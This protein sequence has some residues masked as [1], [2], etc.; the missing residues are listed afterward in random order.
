VWCSA[1]VCTA[2]LRSKSTE[3]VITQIV[4]DKQNN[5]WSYCSA[6]RLE[7]LQLVLM[8][9]LTGSHR[10]DGIG[11]H[12]AAAV[13]IDFVG[14]AERGFRDTTEGQAEQFKHKKHIK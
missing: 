9:A 3:V 4:D 1:K 7:R 11:G 12:V 8:Q 6:C 13:D 5:M 10:A 14:I 2:F